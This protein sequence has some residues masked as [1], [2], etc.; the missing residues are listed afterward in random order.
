MQQTHVRGARYRLRP[1]SVPLHLYLHNKPPLPSFLSFPSSV[2]Q[3]TNYKITN[4]LA[5]SLPLPLPLPHKSPDSVPRR[6]LWQ[7]LRQS[8]DTSSEKLFRY[9]SAFDG[10]KRTVE[11]F[12]LFG[13]G[14]ER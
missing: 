1:S 13:R 9:F 14:K 10:V 7:M 8:G 4:S 11:T 5:F 2:I 6:T 3:I 12:F